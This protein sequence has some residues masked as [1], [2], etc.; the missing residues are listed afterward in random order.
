MRNKGFFWF[1]TILLTAVCLY[2]LS[3]TW[4]SN[5]VEKK[6][7]KEANERVLALISEASKNGNIATLPNNTTVDFSKPEA[8]ELA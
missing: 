3:F 7:E 6:A 2:Q 1:L 8:K 5:S 4:V